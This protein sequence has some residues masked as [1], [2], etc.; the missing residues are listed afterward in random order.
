MAARARSLP[1]PSSSS[2]ALKSIASSSIPESSAD[3][4]S[5]SDPDSWS[6]PFFASRKLSSKAFHLGF[7][8]SSSD[9]SLVAFEVLFFCSLPA[10]LDPFSIS[11]NPALLA[12][13]ASPFFLTPPSSPSFPSSPSVAPRWCLAMALKSAT[14]PR[15]ATF[16]SCL[17]YG[18]WRGSGAIR[19]LVF[20]SLFASCLWANSL[21]SWAW[22]S[23]SFIILVLRLA[24]IGFGLLTGCSKS[25]EITSDI[26]TPFPALEACC[27]PS[28][29][30]SEDSAPDASPGI[31]ASPFSSSLFSSLLEEV[32][33]SWLSLPSCSEFDFGSSF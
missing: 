18:A 3:S 32:F 20:F 29:S 8:C 7:T 28:P 21:R 23:L 4:P 10:L 15:V 16:L 5:S 33:S 14:T 22:A 27:S 19:P 1:S 13:L 30:S 26:P 12:V 11:R 2:L 9:P 24:R 31:S 25:F 17:S 6:Q